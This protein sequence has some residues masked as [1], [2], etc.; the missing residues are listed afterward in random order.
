MTFLTGFLIGLAVGALAG[1]SLGALIVGALQLARR[2]EVP[3][4]REV[5]W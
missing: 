2:H 3:Y 4:G 1:G 5:Q